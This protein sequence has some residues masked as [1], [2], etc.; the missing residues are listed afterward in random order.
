MHHRGSCLCGTVQY[1]VRGKI[2]AA[3]Y[4]HCSICRKANATAFATNASVSAGDFVVVAGE[5]TLKA[6]ESS[7]GVHRVFCSH[8]GS[9]IFSR[10]DAMPDVVRLR[11]GTLDTPMPAPPTAHYFVASKAA[12]YEIHD[13]L[14]QFARFNG[15]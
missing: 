14:P 7:P 9:P 3:I 4:C 5:S 10:R 15:T 13:D 6:F 8:C 12:W 1:E 11:V 2:G